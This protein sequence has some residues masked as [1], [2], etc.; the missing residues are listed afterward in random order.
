MPVYKVKPGFTHGAQKQYKPGDIVELTTEEAAGFLDKLEL[1]SGK[2]AKAASEGE[3][4]D[5]RAAIAG[6]TDAELAAALGVDVKAFT[7]LRQGTVTKQGGLIVNPTDVTSETKA[8]AV[9]GVEQELEAETGKEFIQTSSEPVTLSETESA[10]KPTV[11][12]R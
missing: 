4:N 12:R 5:L 11:P 9:K 7:A 2:K 3:P 8:E 6:A 10:K 1:V